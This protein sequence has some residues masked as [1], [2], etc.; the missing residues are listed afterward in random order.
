[1]SPEIVSPPTSGEWTLVTP[2]FCPD[3]QVL[4]PSGVVALPV[5]I[6]LRQSVVACGLPNWPPGRCS[7]SASRA[8][9]AAA[10]LVSVVSTCRLGETT[11]SLLSQFGAAVQS[12]APAGRN[13]L[14]VLK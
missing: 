2:T 10:L 12:G 1:M 6:A 3:V 7:V 9:V 8:S 14:P 5:A 11:A 13:G 4:L